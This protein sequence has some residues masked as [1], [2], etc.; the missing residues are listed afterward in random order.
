MAPRFCKT[1]RTVSTPSSANDAIPTCKPLI[2]SLAGLSAA[3]KDDILTSGPAATKAASVAL[4]LMKVRRWFLP[5]AEV[6][7]DSFLGFI[8]SV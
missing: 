3:N 7:G 5:T 1:S 6:A 4:F 2:I 8:K